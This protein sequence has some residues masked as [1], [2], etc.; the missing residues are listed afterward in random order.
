MENLRDTP[1][2]Y[3][4]NELYARDPLSNHSKPYSTKQLRANE[5]HKL[6]VTMYHKEHG[7]RKFH[8]HDLDEAI[9]DGWRDVPYIHPRHPKKKIE[10]QQEQESTPLLDALRDE[11]E[12][13]GVTVDLRWGEKR[14]KKEILEAADNGE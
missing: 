13:M 11:A 9:A 1:A 5:E 6:K 3:E 4:E 14:L 7:R 10:D 8:K 12:K 2:R